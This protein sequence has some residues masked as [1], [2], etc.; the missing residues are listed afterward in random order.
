M[1]QSSI[2]KSNGGTTI[3]NERHVSFDRTLYHSTAA[4]IGQRAGSGLA[5]IRPRS[6]I[7]AQV[8]NA[9]QSLND[10]NQFENI[11]GKLSS[12]TEEYKKRQMK[13]DDRLKKEIENHS[14]AVV[15][16]NSEK[17]GVPIIKSLSIKKATSP[18]HSNDSYINTQGVVNTGQDNTQKFF[19]SQRSVAMRIKDT[20]ENQVQILET[21]KLQLIQKLNDSLLQLD[22]LNQEKATLSN[23]LIEILKFVRDMQ[24]ETQKGE[25]LGG[26]VS[27]E[28]RSELRSEKELSH[29]LKED[30]KAAE[31]ERLRILQRIKELSSMTQD[32]EIKQ[33]DMNINYTVKTKTFGDLQEELRDII[34]RIKMNENDV[35]RLNAIIM[36]NKE[37]IRQLKNKIDSTI[38]EK[39]NLHNKI[40]LLQD[41]YDEAIVNYQNERHDTDHLQSR[42]I[43][44][45]STNILFESLKEIHHRNL[46]NVFNHLKYITESQFN[47]KQGFRKLRKL[48]KTNSVNRL[49]KCLYKWYINALKPMRSKNQQYRLSIWMKSKNPMLY[50]LKFW[51][52]AFHISKS[53]THKKKQI[54][55]QMIQSKNDYHLRVSKHFFI[56]WR[57]FIKVNDEEKKKMIQKKLVKKHRSHLARYFAKWLEVS[58]ELENQIHLNG[59]ALRLAHKKYLGQ[60]FNC[61]RGVITDVKAKRIS[62]LNRSWK[63]MRIYT[64][65]RKQMRGQT[66]SILREERKRRENLVK[67]CFDAMRQHK[68]QEKLIQVTSLLN[69]IEIPQKQEANNAIKEVSQQNKSKSKEQGLKAIQKCFGKQINQYFQKWCQF[70]EYKRNL[71][72]KN[73]K[74]MIIRVYLEHLRQSFTAWIKFKGESMIQFQSEEVQQEEQVIS[75]TQ[76]Q[77]KLTQN[78]IEEKEAKQKSLSSKQIRKIMNNLVYK[79]QMELFQQWKSNIDKTIFTLNKSEF[80][81]KKLNRRQKRES[82]DRYLKKINEIKLQEQY[83]KKIQDHQNKHRDIQKKRVY[84]A[85]L[86]FS[87]QHY[88]AK[89]YLKRMLTQLDI[90]V[91]ESAFKKWIRFRQHYDEKSLK[92]KQN[93]LSE[94]LSELKVQIEDKSEII[95]KGQGELQLIQSRLSDNCMNTI[96]QGFQRQFKYNQSYGFKKWLE[97]IQLSRKRK[98]MLSKCALHLNQGSQ[99]KAFKKWKEFVS[100]QIQQVI[101]NSITYEEKY[102]AKV[103][104]EIQNR[105]RL[106]GMSAD[107]ASSELNKLREQQQE[108]MKKHQNCLK[109]LIGRVDNKDFVTKQRYILLQWHDFVQKRKKCIKILENAIQKTLWQDG[110]NAIKEKAKAVYEQRQQLNQANVLVLKYNKIKTRF[111]FGQWRVADQLQI[112]NQHQLVEKQLNT[113]V[114]HHISLK[115]VIKDRIQEQLFESLSHHKVFDVFIAWRNIIK[116]KILIKSKIEIYRENI[117]QSQI[118]NAINKWNQRLKKTKRFR[119]I[120]SK[121]D[122]IYDQQLIRKVFSTIHEQKNISKDFCNSLGSLASIID[123][124]YLKQTFNRVKLES[125]SYQYRAEQSKIKGS[126]FL[127]NILT[128][129]LRKRQAQVLND[130]RVFAVESVSLNSGQRA[131]VKFFM[132]RKIRDYFEEW[133]KESQRREVVRFMNEEGPLAI[134][135]H[136]LKKLV[137]NLKK[138]A[139]DDGIEQKV[140]D[141]VIVNDRRRSIKG[142]EKSVCRLFCYN[143]QLYLLPKCLDRWKQ[144][145]KL[146]K[147]YKK[148]LDLLNKKLDPRLSVLQFAF[149]KWKYGDLE[150]FNQLSQMTKPKLAMINFKNQNSIT[151]LTDNLIHADEALDLLTGQRD[152]LLRRYVGSQ[153]LALAASK[154]QV[155]KTKQKALSKWIDS[156]HSFVSDQYEDALKGNLRKIQALKDRIKALEKSNGDIADQNEDLRTGAL[157]GIEM[158]KQIDDLAREREKLSVDLADK[159][160]TIRKL[161]E[162]N[163]NLSIRLTNAQDEAQNLIR[164]SQMKLGKTS[165]PIYDDY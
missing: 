149:R 131:T 31:L 128:Q 57:D 123:R 8:S 101:I 73:L 105:N 118:T 33:T 116:T 111:A 45:I 38:D 83:D 12:L 85:I 88:Q 64:F 11:Q 32:G 94:K 14:I 53:N 84:K 95:N 17:S 136:I 147:Q 22:K 102:I 103:D 65:T 39:R 80:I 15:T 109:T 16:K 142:I 90:S 152:F 3:S 72:N 55:M 59:M 122:R 10:E 20:Y 30:L 162:D 28:L 21:D 60:L 114:K 124:I 153:R 97:F 91:K 63:N 86:T 130:L 133:K 87:K 40:A 67:C 108:F 138:K 150:R 50:A 127:T 51:I 157:D 115:S 159:A 9:Y 42:H 27:D 41:R 56:K 112:Q 137:Y 68:Q 37:T 125:Q 52:N 71:I 154:A 113:L 49:K 18:F 92:G 54:L 1:K 96:K 135:N 106:H 98:Q 158:A 156:S 79:R 34:E 104:S 139:I 81:L 151:D 132:I 44:I 62:I 145:V 35:D 25:D 141:Q 78:E 6:P 143:D 47:H 134:Q 69:E 13:M 161:L 76:Q 107:Q 48:I 23:E 75:Q 99:E 2:T 66:W 160:I 77:I 129:I 24:R 89:N 61:W 74:Q 100:A 5:G 19:R 144:W 148:S 120:K 46:Q 4:T 43:R 121:I 26:V 29:Q 155:N 140:V 165:D 82:F 70:T 146:R 117:K 36:A 163:Y 164:V 119:D 7:N 110:F 93:D 58:Q 126:D